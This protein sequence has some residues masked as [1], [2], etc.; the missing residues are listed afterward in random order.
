MKKADLDR[1]TALETGE[2]IRDTS[3]VTA[4]F[5]RKLLEAI[6]RGE[7]VQLSGFGKFKLAKQGG[8]PPPHARFGGGDNKEHRQRARFRV[9]F[10]KST[11]LEREVRRNQERPHGKVRG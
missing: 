1:E 9:H 11:T 6:A 2:S 4:T 7:E 8:A 5:L 10:S 3:F